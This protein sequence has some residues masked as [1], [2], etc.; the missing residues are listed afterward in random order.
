MLKENG[1]IE[2]ED[3]KFIERN[4]EE[5]WYIIHMEK[6]IETENSMGFSPVGWSVPSRIYS[7]WQTGPEHPWGTPGLNGLGGKTFGTF[8]Y[9]PNDILEPGQEVQF[10]FRVSLNDNLQIWDGTK[11]IEA[12]DNMIQG[13]S[14]EFDIIFK[15]DQVTD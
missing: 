1:L 13:D 7:V 10:L 9:L 5:G 14:V 3:Y 11:W 12:P 4:D 6:E 15:L 2:G 8:G